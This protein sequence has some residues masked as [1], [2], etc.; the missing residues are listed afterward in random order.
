MST[1]KK[2]VVFVAVVVCAVAMERF[3]LNAIQPN[4]S[5]QLALHQLNG[6]DNAFPGIA[7]V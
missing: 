5:T 4:V 2:L 7:T 3:W 1:V 6:N